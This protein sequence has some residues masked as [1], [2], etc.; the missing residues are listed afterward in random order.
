[1]IKL[2]RSHIERYFECPRKFW[3]QH[4]EGG[5]G[6]EPATTSEA[7]WVGTMVHEQLAAH[8]L[9]K[10][11]PAYGETLPERLATALALAWIEVRGPV[12]ERDYAVISVEK[13]VEI[14]LAPDVILMS[15]VDC[16]V[17]R[18]SDGLLFA[19]P[20]WKTTGMLTNNWMESWR[21]SSQTLA[22]ILDVRE[23]TG[24]E[25]AGVLMEFIYKGRKNAKG[26]HVCLLLPPEE[27]ISI[28][29][30]QAGLTW[31][32]KASYFASKEVW[33]SPAEVDEF[34]KNVLWIADYRSVHDVK[35]HY[36]PRL[37]QTC[38]SNKYGHKCEYL[39]VC[40]GEVDDP[41]GSGLY[42]PRIPHHFLEFAV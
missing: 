27:P 29:E 24:Q 7:L 8:M 33:R 42:I 12:Y 15:R 35:E 23:A 13:E 32:T 22:H 6:F 18:K 40:Y 20:E 9:H 4:Y 26:Q 28:K 31:E 30:W 38:Y 2:S 21:Y 36:R 11:L 34:I 41:F 5:T 14:P 1:M 17:R 10:P 19:G 3:L 39:P 25:G 37:D 16:V